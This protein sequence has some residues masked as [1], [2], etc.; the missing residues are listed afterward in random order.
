MARKRLTELACEKASKAPPGTRVYLWDTVVP[1]LALRVTDTGTKS[2]VVMRRIKGRP[3]P[4]QMTLG[5][6]PDV[7]LT[8]ARELADPISR[9]MAAGIDPI[10]KRAAEAEKERVEARAAAR[11][12]EGIVETLLDEYQNTVVDELRTGRKIRRMFKRYVAPRWKGRH[13]YELR[14]IDV[15]KLRDQIKTPKRQQADKVLE[16]VSAFLKWVSNRDEDFRNPMPPTWRQVKRDEARRTRML[17]DDEIRA[18]WAATETVVPKMY[19]TLVRLLLV[20]GQRLGDWRCARWDELA[21][22]ALVI[23]GARYKSGKQHEVPVAAQTRGL[24]DTLP[25]GG[26]FLFQIRQGPFDNLSKAKKRLDELMLAKLREID[27]AAELKEWRLHDLRRTART[28]LSRAGIARDIAERFV[29]HAVADHIEKTYDV[30]QYWAERTSAAQ[31][32]ADL[33]DRIVAGT[34]AEVI[35]IGARRERTAVA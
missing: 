20:T 11:H 10:A 18:L 33:V 14:R 35:E 12:A 8:K 34:A 17:T 2:W 1:G 16:A 21:G 27:P 3:K 30:H 22:D 19:G 28:L 9:E 7:T 13:I 23:P 31:A 4:V 15:L 26:T 5:R 6:Y 24:I 32:L 29:G 25:S